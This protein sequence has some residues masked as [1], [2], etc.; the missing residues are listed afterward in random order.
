TILDLAIGDHV[1]ALSGIAAN[2]ALNGLNPRTLNVSGGA[3]TR[4]TFD[5]ACTTATGSIEL[6]TSTTG[7]SLD[8]DGYGATL[9][10]NAGRPIASNGTITFNAVAEGNHS[11]RLTGIALNC[12]TD[13]NPRTVP[14]GTD[15]VPIRFDIVCGPPTG[16]I[17]IS[18]TTG[19]VKSD[20][21]GYTV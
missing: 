14:V 11:V 7:D 5:L 4:T 8:P 9:D 18:A 16:S 13:D 19:G 15:A 20:P 12:T 21:D 3:A 10:E 2:C 1:L 6:T 17:Q